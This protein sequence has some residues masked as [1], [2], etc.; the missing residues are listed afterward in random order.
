MI[1]DVSLSR[2]ALDRA[3]DRI[4]ED[5]AGR[6][7]VRAVAALT[8][9]SL[10]WLAYGVQRRR[11]LR[12]GHRTLIERL[13]AGEPDAARECVVRFG[14][15]LR[16]LTRRY[17]YC[18][19]E[20]EDALQDIVVSIWRSAGRFDPRVSNEAA[21]VVMI[22][23]RRLVDRVRKKQSASRLGQS[24]YPCARAGEEVVAASV[25]DRM[26][27]LDEVTGASALMSLLTREQ[28]RVLRLAT[29][30]LS[31]ERV[32]R[33][34][35]MKLSTAKTHLL[36]GKRR[37]RLLAAVARSSRTPTKRRNSDLRGS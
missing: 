24:R 5:H 19:A 10:P 36:R 8:N 9:L 29:L 35:G 17:C 27:L 12:L 1:R 6:G 33:S 14:P 7:V 18:H 30:G 3:E 16:A 26:E 23:R 20:A 15:L 37:M 4:G 21:F 11:G 13:A 28:Q 25:G 31:H 34:L 2:S 32:A 22:G